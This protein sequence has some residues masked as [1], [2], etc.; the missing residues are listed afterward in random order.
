MLHDA[1]A[2]LA[3]QH[4]AI[5]RMVLVAVDVADLAVL[6]VDVDAAAA[7]AHV[8]GGLGDAVGDVRRGIDAITLVGR[9]RVGKRPL[10]RCGIGAAQRSVVHDPALFRSAN[11]A[12]VFGPG[13]RM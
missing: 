12:L 7:G 6:D 13:P 3:A 5:D 10:G 4:A 11:L 2:A 1:G 8:A 9:A